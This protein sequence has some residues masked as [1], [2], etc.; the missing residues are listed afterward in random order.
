M[1][2]LKLNLQSLNAEVL[3]K[4]QLKSIIG[5]LG[6][7]G[8]GEKCAYGHPSCLN[9]DQCARLNAGVCCTSSSHVSCCW[10]HC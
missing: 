6:D 7:V 8:D 10:S 9:D 3:T 4:S 1:K 5:G 2:K